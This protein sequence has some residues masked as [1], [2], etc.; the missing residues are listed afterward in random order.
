MTIFRTSSIEWRNESTVLQSAADQT[1]LNYT[2]DLVSDDL[3]GVQYT[4]RAVAEDGTEYTQTVE[5][6]VMSELCYSFVLQVTI[7]ASS[8]SSQ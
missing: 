3:Q 7:H 5:I 2:I 1:V 4:C 6:Q 8:P